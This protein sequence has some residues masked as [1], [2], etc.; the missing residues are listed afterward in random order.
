MADSRPSNQSE[1]TPVKK[2]N[3]VSKF[4]NRLSSSKK[5]Y[6]KPNNPIVP[7]LKEQKPST[8]ESGT[9]VTISYAPIAQLKS[10]FEEDYVSSEISSVAS[11]DEP[12]DCSLLAKQH[13]LLRRLFL[14]LN[15]ATAIVEEIILL[16]NRGD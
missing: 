1:K 11:V 12:P 7:D 16:N 13:R 9:R 5:Q 10:P 6:D 15:E 8:E 14:T 4:F 3:S 2:R